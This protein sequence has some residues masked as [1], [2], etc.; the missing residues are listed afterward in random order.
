MNNLILKEKQEFMGIQIPV[1]EGGFGEGQKVM[2]AKTVAEIHELELRIVNELINN[3]LDEFEIGIDILDLKNSIVSNDS[4]LEFGFTKQAIANSKN[5][6]LLSEQGYMALVGLM[7]TDK[8]KEIR[9]RL[10]REYFAMRSEIKGNSFDI[11]ELSPEL[12]MFNKMLQAVAKSELE[13][14]KIKQQLNEVNHHAL[15]AKEEASKSREEVQAIREVVTL[16]TNSWRKDTATI[17]NRIATKLGGFGHIQPI[18]EEIYNL[19]DNTYGVKLQSRLLNKQ[20]KMALEGVPKYK[21]DKVNKLDVISDD[22]KLINGYVNIVGK[23][24]IKYGV[25]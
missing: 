3:N 22:K 10:R 15:E 25:A 2:L 4:L 9:R 12:Q 13:Q 1:I 5:I 17:I 24:A 11:S 16:D 14:K 8:A 20:K 19:L 7:R 6:Y 18:R 21:I 23:M